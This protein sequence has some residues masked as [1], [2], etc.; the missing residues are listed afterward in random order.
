[1]GS[2]HNI[3]TDRHSARL[4]ALSLIMALGLLACSESA[5]PTPPA[6]DAVPASLQPVSQPPR[7]ADFANLNPG[8]NSFE[9]GGEAIC[10]DGSPYRF[11]VR[12]GDPEKL[13][14]YL[15]GG[16]AC[17]DGAT[18]DADL[19]PSYQVNLANTDPARAHGVLAFDQPAN[20]F[21][22]YTVVYAPYCSGDVHLG[23]AEQHY[24]APAIDGHEA[25]QIH[26]RHRGLANATTALDWTYNHVFAPAQIFV[27]GSS[28]GSIPSPFYAVLLAEQYPAADVVQLGDASGGY[29]GFANFSPYD[30]WHTDRVVSGLDYVRGI[31]ADEFSFH[32]LYIGAAQRNPAIRYASYDNA[33]DDVQKQ[34]LA[35]G[36]TPAAELKPL[37]EQ[38][39]TE[40]GQAIPDFRYYVAGGTMH[41]ILLRPEV[42]SYEVNGTRFVDW[43]AA[44]ASGRPVSNVMCE[45][46]AEYT[47]T[48]T[49]AVAAD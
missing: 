15:E 28:A 38:N 13:M 42:Y 31:P 14:F 4:L 47:Q 27:T 8:W 29:R 33:E 43:L 1:M 30:I 34:F 45:S 41:T 19:R 7:L 2:Y 32:H 16:G 21:A 26:I 9:P 12:E 46:C 23:D 17:W 24:Q 3:S 35:L 36:G 11:F 6:A 40:I 44:L 25:H 49:D 18:C 39:L 22:D 37:L 20:P 10:S 48:A 5:P